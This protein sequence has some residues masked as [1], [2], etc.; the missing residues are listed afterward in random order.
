MSSFRCSALC[1]ALLS[2][3]ISVTAQNIAPPPPVSSLEI[4][5]NEIAYHIK[6]LS[7]DALEGR[8][9]G[10]HANDIVA[11][12]IAREFE[13]YG[14][15]PAGMNGTFLQPFEV[16]TG[17]KLGNDNAITVKIN[18]KSMQGTL[19]TDFTPLGFSLN[20]RAK[21]ELVFVGYGISAPTMNHDDYTSP[22]LKGKIAIAFTGHPTSDDPHTDFASISSL[23]SKLLFAREAGVAALI[24]VNPEKD[25]LYPLTFDNSASNS[26]IIGV[27]ISRKFADAIFAESGLSVKK[28][29]DEL[30]TTNGSFPSRRIENTTCRLTAEIQ[31]IRKTTNNVIGLLPG[32]DSLARER[33]FVLGGHF[34][35]LGW[36]QNGSLYKGDTPMIHN[37]ADDNASGTAG[38]ME[39]AQYFSEHR[40]RHSILFMGFSGEEMGLLGSGYWV[41]NPTVPLEKISAMFNLDMIGRMPDSTRKVTAQ[42]SGTSPLWEGLLKKLNEHFK[43]NLSM[44]ADGQGA[45]DQSSFYLKNIPV[46][47]FFNGLHSD[48]HKPSDDF[49]KINIS[50]EKEILQFVAQVM[51]SSDEET[52]KVAFTKV[53]GEAATQMRVFSI[54]VG[55]IPDYG[56]NA[57]GF[58]ISGTSPG[59]PADKAGLKAGDVIMQFG[60]TKV[61]NIYDYM[62]ALSFHKP[63]EDVPV[64]VKRGSDTITLTVHVTKK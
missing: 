5:D 32:T 22:D 15:K 19:E 60:E 64:I 1:L 46:L 24:I 52:E 25:E 38:V 7:S 62:N 28:L 21:S 59:G 23:R 35:H 18:G 9:T 11:E 17:V 45:S 51:Q 55:T 34:D 41:S 58:Q 56:A 49:E 27:N 10:T 3:T 39:L 29:T 20:G 12:Y 14:L 63:D 30:A 40:S 53:K 54:Y 16:V 57:D 31:L 4:T 6:W 2:T 48:Y 36:G 26:G 42:G 37:G 50:G 47:F 33:Y 13:R 44:V 8:G 43:F 61:K